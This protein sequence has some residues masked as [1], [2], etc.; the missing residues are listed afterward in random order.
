MD[1]I[2]VEPQWVWLR[3]NWGL[4]SSEVSKRLYK[5]KITNIDQP[6]C[7]KILDTLY[8]AIEESLKVAVPKLK[9]NLLDR[10]SPWWNENLSKQRRKLDM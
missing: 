8:S 2:E 7:D 1:L 10:N 9:L 5:T 3:A 6:A 4:F